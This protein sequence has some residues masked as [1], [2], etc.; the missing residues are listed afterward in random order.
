M[1]ERI[2]GG[3]RYLQGHLQALKTEV[4]LGA[5]RGLTLLVIGPHGCGKF[6]VT[7]KELKGARSLNLSQ[8]CLTDILSFKK[9]PVILDELDRI[10]QEL[11][12]DVVSFLTDVEG[13]VVGLAVNE[14]AVP[15]AVRS[16]LGPPIYMK[17]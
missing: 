12:E 13:I 15:Q 6:M 2:V 9:G 7:E 14:D 4:S 5:T 16:R 11:V 1:G 8:A 17:E 10:P 3:M